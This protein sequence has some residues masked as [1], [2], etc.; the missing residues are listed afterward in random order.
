MATA[1][2]VAWGVSE[3]EPGTAGAYPLPQGTGRTVLAC[4]TRRALR[5]KRKESNELAL[6]Q[7]WEGEEGGEEDPVPREGHPEG[8][9][10]PRT[11]GTRSHGRRRADGLGSPFPDVAEAAG[12]IQPQALGGGLGGDI[13]A[14]SDGGGGT[15]VPEL[16]G[17]PGSPSSPRSPLAPSWPCWEGKA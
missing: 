1:R 13:P 8:W 5:E 4:G 2:R 12:S 15:H 7:D 10:D 9:E 16:T 6:S 14:Q 11:R 17:S 3:P